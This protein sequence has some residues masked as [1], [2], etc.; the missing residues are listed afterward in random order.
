[1]RETGISY[2]VCYVY[3]LYVEN[4]TLIAFFSNLFGSL[5]ISLDFFLGLENKGSV[6]NLNK[7]L[8]LA[9]DDDNSRKHKFILL[10]QWKVVFDVLFSSFILKCNRKYL[11]LF[12]LYQIGAMQFFDL[13]F[14][15]YISFTRLSDMFAVSVFEIFTFN[16]E[17]VKQD[18]VLL[19]ISFYCEGRMSKELSV[20]L[21]TV[22]FTPKKGGKTLK[23]KWKN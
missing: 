8:M 21:F 17:T 1:M 7:D 22:Q 3:M 12:E 16:K 4:N 6:R 20:N 11:T 18:E 9:A 23:Y 19:L 5:N 10:L 14:L 13:F 2:V 15:F